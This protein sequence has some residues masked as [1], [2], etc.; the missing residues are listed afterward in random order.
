MRD[1][2]AGIEGCRCAGGIE[3]S[4]ISPE[5]EMLQY[6]LDVETVIVDCFSQG[7]CFVELQKLL[8][9][10]DVEPQIRKKTFYKIFPREA[11]A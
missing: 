11:F 9:L 1:S 7:F 4:R 3:I 5:A 6:T 10:L 8:L 2:L